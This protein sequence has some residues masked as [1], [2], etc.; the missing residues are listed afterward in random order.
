M[1]NKNSPHSKQTLTCWIGWI[2]E[3]SYFSFPD[4]LWLKV[5]LKILNSSTIQL[6]EGLPIAGSYCSTC[7]RCIP[8]LSLLGRICSGTKECFPGKTTW[9]VPSNS[10][11]R[12]QHWNVCLNCYPACSLQYCEVIRSAADVTQLI[13]TATSLLH[14]VWKPGLLP[15][16]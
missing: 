8:A 2:Y 1:Q 14:T 7:H 12:W 16:V 11:F 3:N 15:F 9:R 13:I 10:L 6:C 5:P 4:R